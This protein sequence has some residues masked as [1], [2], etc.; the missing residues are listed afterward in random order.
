MLFF[1]LG[2]GIVRFAIWISACIDH[3]PCCAKIW[4]LRLHLVVLL[5]VSLGVMPFCLG[6]YGYGA[7]GLSSEMKSSSALI[8]HSIYGENEEIALNFAFF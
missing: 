3:S 5:C 1:I 7:Y 2:V 8:F 4:F 6:N